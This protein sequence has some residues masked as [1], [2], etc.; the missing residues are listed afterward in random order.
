MIKKN[1]DS[2]PFLHPVDPIALGIPDYLQIITQPMDLSTIENKLK[3]NDY[4]TP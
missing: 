2:T 1:K 4:S 3:N